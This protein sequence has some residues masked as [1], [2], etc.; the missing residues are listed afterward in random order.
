MC[1]CVGRQCGGGWEHGVIG[2]Q[3]KLGLEGA[4]ATELAG[5][6]ICLALAQRAREEEEEEDGPALR[7]PLVPPSVTGG[8]EVVQSWI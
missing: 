2:W 7:L 6:P 8:K 4:V 5:P 1:L 3:M